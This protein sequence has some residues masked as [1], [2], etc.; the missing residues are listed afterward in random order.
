[1]KKILIPLMTLMFIG[2]SPKIPVVPPAPTEAASAVTEM[3]KT[4]AGIDSSLDDNKKIQ[5]TINIQKETIKEQ[6][7]DIKDALE[8]AERIKEKI[9]VEE[10]VTN[11]ETFILVEQIKKIS[12][13]NLFLERKTK[14]LEDVNTNQLKLLEQAKKDAQDTF[15]KLILKE[16]EANELRQQ[17]KYLST[18]LQQKNDEV[19]KLSKSLENAK[20][21]KK[22]VVGLLIGSV[23][24]VILFIV[25]SVGIKYIKPL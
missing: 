14:E 10:K 12:V 16:N 1:M 11:E 3:K 13:R 4:Q 20:V 18:N 21:Y 17:H 24:C 15:Q 6:Q 25:T 19:L 9:R 23:I 5:E 7:N 22:W 8:Q 2:C